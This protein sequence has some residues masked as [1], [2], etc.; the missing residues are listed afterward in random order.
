METK[1]RCQHGWAMELCNSQIVCGGMCLDHITHVLC[2]FSTF[3]LG[4]ACIFAFLVSDYALTTVFSVGLP[5]VLIMALFC[6]G[7]AMR[8]LE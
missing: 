7:R 8:P 2:L 4:V 3:L 6:L 5:V 1:K